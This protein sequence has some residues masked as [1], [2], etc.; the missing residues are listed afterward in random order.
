MGT[1]T[2]ST[3]PQYFLRGA[4]RGE[5][6]SVYSSKGL[7][8]SEVEDS[9][10]M[11]SPAVMDRTR[12]PAMINIRFGALWRAPP[13]LAVLR[14]AAWT[15]WQ[16]ALWWLMLRPHGPGIPQQYGCMSRAY[17]IAGTHM[18]VRDRISRLVCHYRVVRI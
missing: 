8:S 9:D 3:L 1:A 2:N 11:E 5:Y 10:S 13:P 16:A 6:F 12:V 15:S 7:V 4:T 17:D 14:M 18:L